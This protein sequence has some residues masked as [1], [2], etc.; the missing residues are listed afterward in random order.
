MIE[1]HGQWRRRVPGVPKFIVSHL[2]YLSVFP[3]HTLSE[4]MTQSM[5]DSYVSMVHVGE[6]GVGVVLM[7]Q[8]SA[9]GIALILVSVVLRP[10]CVPRQISTSRSFKDNLH[11]VITGILIGSGS[12]FVLWWCSAVPQSLHYHGIIGPPSR[13]VVLAGLGAGAFVAASEE[14]YFRALLHPQGRTLFR[15]LPAGS[16]NVAV[17]V[18]CHLWDYRGMHHLAVVGLLG[19]ACVRYAD[20]DRTFGRA[21]ICHALVNMTFY[22]LTNYHVLLGRGA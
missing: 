7:C 2:A 18:L 12:F 21:A 10:W 4:F 13:W 20:T 1:K 14:F 3:I 5:I 6:A 8:A 17:F 11:P 16:V 9:G 15:P 19:Y 22:T